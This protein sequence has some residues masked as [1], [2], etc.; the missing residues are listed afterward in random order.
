MKTQY[1]VR[2]KYINGFRRNIFICQKRS[3]N[4][5]NY[6]IRMKYIPRNVPNTILK[7]KDFT[8]RIVDIVSEEVNEHKPHVEVI[9]VVN[10]IIQ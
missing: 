5:Y 7:T 3:N 8:S 2:L 6:E 9:N 1:I 10:N 4:H